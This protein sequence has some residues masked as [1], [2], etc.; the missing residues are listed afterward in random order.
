MPFPILTVEQLDH[1]L[2]GRRFEAAD[3]DV[4]AVGVRARNV[5]GF[6]ATGLAKL[7]LCNFSVEG[8]SGEVIFPLQQPKPGLRHNQVQVTGFSTDGTVAVPTLD[9]L[10]GLDFEPNCA[11]MTTAAIDH[12]IFPELWLSLAHSL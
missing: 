10:W 5:E 2:L 4:V 6:D 9:S 3:V 1:Q 8:I 12:G 11:T 7:V